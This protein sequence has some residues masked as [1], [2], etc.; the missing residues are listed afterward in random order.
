MSPLP[1]T[2]SQGSPST[3][4]GGALITAV[5]MITLLSV[6]GAVLAQIASQQHASQSRAF[7][8]DQ[9]WYAAL[10]RLEK[11]NVELRNNPKQCP[12]EVEQDFLDTGLSTTLICLSYPDIEPDLTLYDLMASACHSDAIIGSDICRTARSQ[13]IV[14]TSQND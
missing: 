4:S 1:H 6:V 9:A 12:T 8:A 10:G 5:I 11:A 14:P 3:Q 13:L 2:F 7:I